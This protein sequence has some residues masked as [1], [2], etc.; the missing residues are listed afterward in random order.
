MPPLDEMPPSRFPALV[1]NYEQAEQALS[2]AAH[3]FSAAQG[4]LNAFLGEAQAFEGE[5]S[6]GLRLRL[7]RKGLGEVRISPV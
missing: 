7:E 3:E 1:D 2:V 4:A 5:C 6:S